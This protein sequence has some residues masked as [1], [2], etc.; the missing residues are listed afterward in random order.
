MRLGNYYQYS[1]NIFPTAVYEPDGE[2]KVLVPAYQFSHAEF[3]MTDMAGNVLITKQLGDGITVVGDEFVTHLDDAEMTMQGP[4]RHQFVVYD[5]A[6]NRLPPV[7]MGKEK[8]NP[9]SRGA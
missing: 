8:V 3:V 6:G 4:V 1:D 7:F 9:T 5:A 2:D